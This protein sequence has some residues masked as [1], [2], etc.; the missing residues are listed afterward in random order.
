MVFP[1][2]AWA[3]K[4]QGSEFESWLWHLLFF[5]VLGKYYF[6]YVSVYKIIGIAISIN[7]MMHVNTYTLNVTFS[8]I[9]CS[10]FSKIISIS[11]QIIHTLRS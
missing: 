9:G 10:L 7:E 8:H 4:S 3:L 11:I 1:L 5:V 2:G 6:V